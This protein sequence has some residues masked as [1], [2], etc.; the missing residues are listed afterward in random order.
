M[1]SALT[2]EIESPL[3]LP[4]G[5]G[6][7]E[8]MPSSPDAESACTLTIDV[9]SPE[10]GETQAELPSLWCIT[11]TAPSSEDSGSRCVSQ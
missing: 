5:V 11:I 10:L 3:P 1:I 8:K 2:E 7:R 6:H 9:Q 4:P